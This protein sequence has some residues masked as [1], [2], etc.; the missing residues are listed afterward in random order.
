MSGQS[1]S[2]QSFVQ[3][4][5]IDDTAVVRVRGPLKNAVVVRLRDVLV[6]LAQA[7]PKRIVADL[8]E[9]TELRSAALGALVVGALWSKKYRVEFALVA[10]QA[11][12]DALTVARLERYFDLT[13]KP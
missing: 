8:S 6:D 1:Q 3:S 9:I 13:E 2:P 10:S 4:E 11:V 12:R 5:T 7:R